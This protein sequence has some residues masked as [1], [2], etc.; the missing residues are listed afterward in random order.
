MS[1]EPKAAQVH[2]TDLAM[3][4]CATRLARLGELSVDKGGERQDAV[5]EVRTCASYSTA[6]ARFPALTAF[7]RLH[8]P[9]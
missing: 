1:L 4:R 7:A 8:I 5:L 2:F 9:H 6:S 3:S